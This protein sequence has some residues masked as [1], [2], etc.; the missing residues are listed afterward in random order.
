MADRTRRVPEARDAAASRSVA[1]FLERARSVAPPTRTEAVQRLIFAIDATAS[2]QPTWDLAS[3]LHAE[4]FAEVERL[5]HVAVQLVYF[6]GVNE[7]RAS[8]WLTTPAELRSRMLEVRC[9]AGRTQLVHLL[10]HAAQEAA[11]SPVRALIFI[12]DAFEES[13][14]ELLAAAG[15]LALRQVPVF[16]F[17]EGDDRVAADAL[18]AVA[19]RTGGAYV[20]FDPGSAAALRELLAAAVRFATGGRAALLEYARTARLG[21][22]RQ[23]LSQLG[24]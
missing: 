12:G 22:A 2:R 14:D 16:A 4:L 18:G 17:Q 24:P 3:E 21:G 20:R 11:R 7:F 23:L 19:A 10:A 5:G 9:A 6:R 8:A 1:T 15:Q 13:R